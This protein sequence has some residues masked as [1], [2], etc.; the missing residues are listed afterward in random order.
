MS[1]LGH[2]EVFRQEALLRVH[3]DATLVPGV[4]DHRVEGAVLVAGRR[5]QN[6]IS[7][8]FLTGGCF[9]CTSVPNCIVKNPDIVG[10]IVEVEAGSQIGQVSWVCIHSNNRKR[11][12][13][14]KKKLS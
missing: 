4:W 7:K 6:K 11:L 14:K 1:K 10:R 12:F 3:A 2:I 13:L 9:I 5:H 8:R